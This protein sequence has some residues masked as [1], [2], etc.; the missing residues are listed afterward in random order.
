MRNVIKS[1][2]VVAGLLAAQGA[3]ASSWSVDSRHSRVGFLVKH[4]MVSEVYGGFRKFSGTL[5]LDDKDVTKSTVTVEIDPASLDTADGDRDGHVKGADFLDV[6]K[7]PK[8]TF[9]STKV[10]K[11]GNQLKVTGNLQIKD[12][13]KE[14]VLMVDGPSAEMKTPM[15]TTM[16]A[17][18]ATGTFNRK[19]F[20]LVWNKVLETGGVALGEDITLQI[21]VE[22]AKNAE[23]APAAAKP[24]AKDAKPA[25]KK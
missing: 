2:T 13:T 17:V 5:V 12:V 20:G 25:K 21:D 16:S 23:P 15:G 14:V 22:L 4:M 6:E 24:A 19:D 3:L 10:E 11:M 1:V 9:K 7:F 8:M 18:K